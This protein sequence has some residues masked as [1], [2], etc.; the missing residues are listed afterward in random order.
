MG[1]GFAIS[2]GSCGFEKCF[3][4]GTGPKY[5]SLK[6]AIDQLHHMRGPKVLELVNEHEVHET[7]FD[8]R[9]YHCRSCGQLR[10]SFWVR[11]VYDDDQV[12][13]THFLCGK[14]HRPMKPIREYCQLTK[15]PC[16]CCNANKLVVTTEAL[17]WFSIT[18]TGGACA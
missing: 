8:H 15:I 14:G 2:C 3:V 16:P 1:F 12:Y 13:E 4:V 17:G 9:I 5:S 7:D 10:N 11:I 18:A 6:A